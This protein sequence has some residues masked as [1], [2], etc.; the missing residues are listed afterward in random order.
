M[1][2]LPGCV[3]ETH[4]SIYTKEFSEEAAVQ[5]RVDAAMEYLRQGNTDGA[6]RHLRAAYEMDKRSA[7]VNNGLA[8]A[9][10]ITGEKALAEQHYKSALRA[11]R[12]MTAARNNYAVFLY[13]EGRYA[14]ACRHMRRVIKD[15]LYEG[16]ADAFH[17]LG[18]CELRVGNVE[19]AEE[20]FTRS[21]ALNRAHTGSML[22]LADINLSQGKYAQAMRYYQLFDSQSE[23][24]ARSLYVGIQLAEKF[25]EEDSRASYA[26]ALKN[27][28]PHSE[29][30]LRYK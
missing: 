3:T 1:L 2:V 13:G 29:E 16:R 8:L 24:S 21:L 5:S 9:F 20:A 11:N 4:N 7:A 23:Q 17:N 25:D 28:Y 12:D 18:Q 19:E 15:T 30:Y 22:E 6:I 14:E 10:Q 27:L 26:L